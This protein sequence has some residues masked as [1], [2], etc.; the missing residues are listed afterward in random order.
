M[1][2]TVQITV[3]ETHSV[4]GNWRTSSQPR[5][6][7]AL[8]HGAGADMHHPFMRRTQTLISELGGACLRFNFPYKESGRKAP[9]RP[10]LLQSTWRAV[11]QHAHHRY[12]TLDLIAAGKSMGGRMATHVV[13]DGSDV[14]ALVLFGYPLHAAKTGAAE[15]AQ[16][17]AQINV[18][19]LFIQGERDRLCALPRLRPRLAEIPSQVCLHVVPS[20]D[21]SYNVPKRG[22]L[23]ED[24]VWA[25]I[26][27][28][29]SH[30]LDQHWPAQP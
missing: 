20:G 28:A 19:C 26:R 5:V 9:D 10:A 21:H 16:H 29:L 3:S 11:I 6:A 13:A 27:D 30:W 2:S 14:N 4:T 8:A 23:S 17:F 24:D 1:S 22:A 18:P 12:P 15:R 25:G 7:V